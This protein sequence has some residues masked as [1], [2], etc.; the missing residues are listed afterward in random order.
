MPIDNGIE[1]EALDEAPEL[2]QRRASFGEI[3][4]VRPNPSLGEKTKRLS[5]FRAF[6]YSEDLNFHRL[7]CVDARREVVGGTL[8]MAVPMQD[9]GEHTYRAAWWVPG[10]HAQT[11]WG[12]FARR[13]TALPTRLERW[14]TPDGDFIELLRLDAGPARPRLFVLHGLEGSVRSHYL[15]GLL[16]VARQ[17]DWGADI[18]LF[19]GC[20]TEPN[21]TPR[22]YHSGE[23][24]DLGFAV[25]RVLEEFPVAPIVACGV[26]L[27]GNVLLKW[28]GERGSSLPTRIRAAATI[29]VPYDLGRGSRHLSRGFSRVYERHFLRSLQRK[30]KEKLERFPQLFDAAAMLGARTL[31]EVDDA[32]T[33]P[34][35]GFRD[36]QDYYSRSSSIHF[37]SRIRIPTLLVSAEDDPFLPAD[38]LR[39][40]RAIATGNRALTLEFTRHGGHVG[41][42]GGTPLRPTYH[43]ERRIGSFFDMVLSANA[44][45]DDDLD[46]F[47]ARASVTG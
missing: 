13:P 5:G 10:P 18:L 8:E 30:A 9:S 39:D 3:H 34:V 38:V 25:S 24:T 6:L 26:S 20:G 17:R 14:A 41:F 35:H 12:R 47:P 45:T 29:S 23:T 40:V 31:W 7:G 33:A 42:V 22:F 28:L 21:Q 36:A 4:K 37:L 15:G 46:R 43:A 11:L 19:R 16:E 1:A 27:G 2:T 44:R 32:V